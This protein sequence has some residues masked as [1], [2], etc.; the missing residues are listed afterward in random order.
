MSATSQLWFG[1]NTQIILLIVGHP[2]CL[3][4]RLA[5]F[6]WVPDIVIIYLLG[7]WLLTWL[8]AVWTPPLQGC[9]PRHG[10]PFHVPAVSALGSWP[11]TGCLERTQEPCNCSPCPPSSLFRCTWPARSFHEGPLVS[12][13]LWCPLGKGDLFAILWPKWALWVPAWA[14]LEPWTESV[15][16]TS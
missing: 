2:S 9:D 10:V 12:A 7:T 3:C 4:A 15:T 5:F 14:A 6:H 8:S 16:M 13:L 1:F 11:M